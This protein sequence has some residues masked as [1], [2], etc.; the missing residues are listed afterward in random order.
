MSVLAGQPV[1]HRREGG[2]RVRVGRVPAGRTPG[3]HRGHCERFASRVMDA[4]AYRN[5]IQLDF[6][7]FGKPVEN[8]FIKRFN[9]RLRDEC[10]NVYVFFTLNYV[11]KELA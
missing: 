11:R 10:L 9:G 3:D 1:A 4:W 2:T 5:G 7:R 8:S 6:I